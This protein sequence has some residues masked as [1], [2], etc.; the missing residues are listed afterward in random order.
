MDEMVLDLK[1]FVEKLGWPRIIRFD[2]AYFRGCD[3]DKIRLVTRIKVF[4]SRSVQK[5]EFSPC[6]AHKPVETLALQFPPDRAADQ[7]AMA[8]HVYLRILRHRHLDRLTA[9]R[10]AGQVSHRTC[11]LCGHTQ[12]KSGIILDRLNGKGNFLRAIGR[13][14]ERIDDGIRF[15]KLQ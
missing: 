10:P 1:V 15:A 8:C 7:T 11:P 13:I 9:A 2:S 12:D 4:H 14:F 6:S 5:V 3:K